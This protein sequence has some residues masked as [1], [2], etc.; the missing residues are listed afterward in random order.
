MGGWLERFRREAVPALFGAGP[1][2]AGFAEAGPDFLKEGGGLGGASA[3]AQGES[4]EIAR[5]FADVAA[6]GFLKIGFGFG[7]PAGT[8]E[9]A[10][11]EQGDGEGEHAIGAGVDF[12]EEREGLVPVRD[13]DRV[14]RNRG[15]R[16]RIVLENAG[17]CFGGGGVGFDRLAGVEEFGGEGEPGLDGGCFLDG[18]AGLADA[19]GTGFKAGE[20]AAAGPGG[21]ALGEKFDEEISD[22]S[23]HRSGEQNPE[24]PIRPAGFENVNHESQLDQPRELRDD[25]EGHP[26]FGDEIEERGHRER[27]A[28]AGG[29]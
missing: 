6:G 9:G 16:V 11:A 3:G 22:A 24:P 10:A 29:S 18:G 4:E 8:E 19:P 27:R 13:L 15:Q 23:E 25:G 7:R 26:V 28:E 14:T 5:F 2:G 21:A 17:Q 12:A 20:E 1:G